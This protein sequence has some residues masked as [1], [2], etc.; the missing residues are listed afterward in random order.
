LLKLKPASSH[1]SLDASDPSFFQDPYPAYAVVRQQCPIF[2]WEEYGQWCFSRIADVD[3]ILRDRR[4]GRDIFHVASRAELGWPETPAHLA[5][6]YAVEAHSML[7][8][9]PP[10]HTRLRAQVNRSFVSHRIEAMRPRVE[11][12]ANELI[13]RFPADQPVDL[14]AAYCTPIPITVICELLGVPVDKASELLTWSHRMVAMYRFG[15][16]RQDEDL[17]VAASEAFVAFLRA[18]VAERRR[19]PCGDLISQLAGIW[20]KAERLS[21]DELISTCILLLNAGH[22]A[23]VH[24]LGNGIKTLIEQER[25]PARLFANDALAAETVEEILRFDPPLHMFSRFALEDLEIAGLAL[26]KGD[27]VGLLLGSAGRDDARFVDAQRF[28]PARSEKRHVAFGAGIHFCLGASLAR[29]EM[30]VAL[31]VLFRRCPRIDLAERPRYRN[32]WHF[33]GLERLLVSCGR[34]GKAATSCR[35]IG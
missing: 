34:T 28:D 31:A 32:S 12:L 19:V 25:D 35:Q 6:F 18:H 8:R 14:L 29:L 16:T 10:V 9:E 26:R 23:T 20:S 33:H 17:A 24:A 2:F 1:I 7:E 13:D 11:Q 4:F 5:P 3:A 21:D 27:R 22:E 15:R 30:Q